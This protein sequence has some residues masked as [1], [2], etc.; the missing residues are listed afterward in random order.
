LKGG[1]TLFPT[2]SKRKRDKYQNRNIIN[3]KIGG[4][5]LKGDTLFH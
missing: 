4:E 1:V 3:L 5:S 2:M